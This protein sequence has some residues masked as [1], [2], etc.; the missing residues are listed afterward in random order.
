MPFFAAAGA[1]AGTP[2]V[3]DG[4]GTSLQSITTGWEMSFP[5]VHFLLFLPV[6]V[7]AYFLFPPRFRRAWLLLCSYYFYFFAAP[8]Y[9]IVL[10][11]ATC[12]TYLAGRLLGRVRS[13][14]AKRVSLAAGIVGLVAGLSLFKYSGPL[15]DVLTPFFA[16]INIDYH[17]GFFV[18]AAAVGISFYT[19]TAIGY[20]IDTYRG[21]IPAEKNLLTF[22]LFLGF[23]PS[24]ISGPISRAGDL[25]P[26]LNDT[27]RRFNPQTAADA[28][29][30]MAIGFF[31]KLAVADTL[32]VFTGAIY[33]NLPA[34]S[35]LTLTYAAV[36]FALQ[37]YFDFSGYSDI[38]LGTAQL[39]GIRL[40]QNFNTPYFSTNF[41]GLWARW[42]MSLSSWLQD[43]IFTPLVW[44]R[45]PEKLPIIGKRA[46]NP[47]VLSS[48]F[49]VF[50]VSGLWHG[51]T[52]CFIVWGLLQ[53]VFRIGEELLHRVAG[54]PKKHPTLP[55]RIGKTAVVMVL[56]VESLVL[57]RVGMLPGGTLG[58]AASALWRQFTNLSLSQTWADIYSA[59]YTG[60]FSKNI[61]VLAFIAFSFVCLAAALWADW[62][63]CFKLKGASLATGLAALRPRLR[64][65]VYF[66]LVLG[67]F[68]A[69]LAQSGGFGGASFLYGGF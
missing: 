31:K 60:F 51:D 59:V 66:L 39:L 25:I 42:H 27:T 15:A 2:G 44:S 24:V 3:L 47:P 56:W 33:D 34:Y 64:W 11:N 37:L 20:L 8:K 1:A 49:L 67:C 32:A 41:S 68:A 26:Q 5:A 46:K 23:F 16:R 28:L 38:A 50:L 45:W 18:T 58:T 6:A 10:I 12:F 9:L 62:A 55:S 53:G 57:F 19:F 29:R 35:G 48:L 13:L 7:G 69:F 65:T 52:L 40:P 14:A 22:A 63:Q 30:L 21:D 54:K 61:L 4:I 17:G 36:A 43:Y